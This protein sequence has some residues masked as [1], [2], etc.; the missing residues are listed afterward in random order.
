MLEAEG[1]P[2]SPAY[3]SN[4]ALEDAQ[5]KHLKIEVS[6]THPE[7]GLFRTVRNPLNFDGEPD[8]VVTAPPTL[9]EHGAE[10]RKAL[11]QQ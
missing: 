6:A 3:D 5:A 10:I 7:M 2:Y 11:K 8:L 1:V 9:D 4:E